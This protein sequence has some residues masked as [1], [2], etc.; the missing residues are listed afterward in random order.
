MMNNI[1]G[2]RPLNYAEGDAVMDSETRAAIIDYI[3]SMT[4]DTSDSLIEALLNMPDRDLLMAR[5]RVEE[6]YGTIDR[7]LQRTPANIL[8]APADIERM[9]PPVTG[10]PPEGGDQM[11]IPP[12]GSGALQMP[13]PDSSR[14]GRNFGDTGVS[15]YMASPMMQDNIGTGIPMQMARGGIMS[16]GRR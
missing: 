4:G 15:N 6:K 8:G 10:V 11:L 16:L 9:L 1:M 3:T 14:L 13:Q 5:Q 12:V 7:A 2:F